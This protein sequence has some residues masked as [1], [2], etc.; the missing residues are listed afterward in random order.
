MPVGLLTIMQIV[1]YNQ[2][3]ISK[4]LVKNLSYDVYIKF[5]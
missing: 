3:F 4:I 5:A 1:L 2:I